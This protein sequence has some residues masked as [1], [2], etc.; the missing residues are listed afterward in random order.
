M[1]GHLVVS[2]QPNHSD[3]NPEIHLILLA[4]IQQLRGVFIGSFF[5]W[6]L[7]PIKVSFWIRRLKVRGNKE[8]LPCCS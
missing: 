3:S 5:S 6:I 2:L 8:T 7:K 4:K 1:N